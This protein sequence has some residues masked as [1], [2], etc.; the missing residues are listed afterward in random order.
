MS[1]ASTAKQS[2]KLYELVYDSQTLTTMLRKFESAFNNATRGSF[3]IA[4]DGR[5]GLSFMIEQNSEHVSRLLLSKIFTQKRIDRFVENTRE[6]GFL[7]LRGKSATGFLDIATGYSFKF[8]LPGL[9]LRMEENAGLL[10]DTG[11]ESN[12]YAI[13][14]LKADQL[15]LDLPG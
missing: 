12:G 15:T 11:S 13:L 8:S 2:R 10:H 4:T 7:L 14:G 1:N 9:D 6:M 3:K 5:D